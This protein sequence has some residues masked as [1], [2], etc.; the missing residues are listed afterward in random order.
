VFAGTIVEVLPARRGMEVIVDAGCE[1]A[2]LLTAESVGDLGLSKGSPVFAAVKAS[3]VRV[4]E[5]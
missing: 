5:R 1:I 4:L 2:A 3:A